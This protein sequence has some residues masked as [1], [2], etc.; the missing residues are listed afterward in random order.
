MSSIEDGRSVD[1]ELKKILNLIEAGYIR[2]RNMSRSPMVVERRARGR[3]PKASLDTLVRCFGLFYQ[4]YKVQQIPL[5]RTQ[6]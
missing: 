6:D 1:D 4:L 3:I 2:Y 5:L